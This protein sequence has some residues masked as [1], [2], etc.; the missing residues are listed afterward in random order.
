MNKGQTYQSLLKNR[1]YC[2]RFHKSLLF[3]SRTSLLK[4]IRISVHDLRHIDMA[5]LP[6]ESPSNLMAKSG[7]CVTKSAK[8]TW[9]RRYYDWE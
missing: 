5:E 7:G 6:D 4:E 9:R 1:T 3:R 8:D 2:L